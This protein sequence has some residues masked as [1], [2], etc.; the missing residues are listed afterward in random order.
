MRDGVVTA[1]R[2]QATTIAHYLHEHGYTKASEVAEALSLPKARQIMYR[3][4]YGWFERVSTGIYRLTPRGLRE[5]ANSKAGK[6]EGL[7]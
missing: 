3:D 2:Q 7:T 5:A 6:E 4:V 1:Y